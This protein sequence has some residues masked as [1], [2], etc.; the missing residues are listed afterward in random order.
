MR[1]GAVL[2]VVLALMAAANVSEAD[3][4]Q[5]RDGRPIE[6]LVVEEND[7]AAVVA[8]RTAG[9]PVRA[10]ILPSEIIRIAT[11]PL[12][13]PAARRDVEENAGGRPEP[14]A[15]PPSHS[16]YVIPIS[17]EI[18]RAVTREVVEKAFQEARLRK[19]DV[20]VL[21]INTPGGL[22][23]EVG[24]ILKLLVENSDLPVVAYVKNALAE[25]AQI[26]L[27]CK[28]VYVSRSSRIG[29]VLSFAAGPNGIPVEL[30]K[31]FQK[32]WAAS[33]RTAVDMGLHS[34]LLAEAL[35]NPELEVFIANVD[36]KPTLS[37]TAPVKDAVPFKRR[38]RLLTLTSKQAVECGLAVAEIGDYVELGR[39]LALLGWR[40]M[41]SAGAILG[42]HKEEVARTEYALR[43]EAGLQRLKIVR[44]NKYLGIKPQLDQIRG[45]LPKLWSQGRALEARRRDLNDQYIYE[46]NK[47]NHAYN[48]MEVGVR[49]PQ[50][51]ER[52]KQWAAEKTAEL[53]EEY[54]RALEPVKDKLA[55]L[56]GLYLE[57]VKQLRE[58][59]LSLEL[60]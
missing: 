57:Q 44:W 18:G 26:A 47:I 27:T 32:R 50:R 22:L 24:A 11:A 29:G 35:T 14:P 56:Q 3:I 16:Y 5:M 31:E 21:E 20:V 25:A 58:L 38:G 55:H 34:P 4:L 2:A 8:I 10:G 17:G 51:Q 52:L 28:E 15:A 1:T 48:V 36:G 49:D 41:G 43:K 13:E 33:C 54:L 6:G 46:L 7:A 42:K 60:P 59:I 37:S 9:D 12:P 45:V 19:A 53:N 23:S 40:K 39:E 30:E